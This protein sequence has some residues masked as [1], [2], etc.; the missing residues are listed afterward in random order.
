MRGQTLVETAL[1][2]PLFLMVICGIIV[3][4]IGVFYQQQLTNAAR[5]AARFAA[6]NSATA[7][8]PTVP[9]QPYNPVSPPLSYRRCDPAESGWPR[10]TTHA[11]DAVFGLNADAVHV[12]ACWSGYRDTATNA[13]DAPPPGVHDIGGVPTTIS[14][15]FAQCR[16]DGHDP[17]GELSGIRCEAALPT[18]DEA[19]AMSEA[20]GR[21]I[22]NTVT[23]YVCFEWHPPL[24]GFLLIPDTVVQRAAITEAIQRQ[25]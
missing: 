2:L 8:C 17:T 19:S 25:Q 14:S 15:T 16:I 23:A 21:A 6:I 9:R 5:E 4:G 12:S 11:R 24:A 1:I 13:Y 10:M 3:L 22:A 20:V 7:E 18:A